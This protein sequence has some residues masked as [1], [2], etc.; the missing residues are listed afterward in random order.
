MTTQTAVTPKQIKDLLPK[1]P[2]SLYL[3]YPTDGGGVAFK[4]NFDKD[5][6][7]VVT[8]FIDVGISASGQ[9]THYDS[10]EA[11]DA[12]IDSAINDV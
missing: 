9:A 11:Q 12:L 4:A 2:D 5:I 1:V 10:K 3:V 6:A 7:R 8:K